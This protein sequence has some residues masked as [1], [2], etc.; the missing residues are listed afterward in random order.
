MT[1]IT[2]PAGLVEPGEDVMVVTLD[3]DELH[4]ARGH[5]MKYFLPSRRPSMCRGLIDLP[6]APAPYSE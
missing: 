1:T 2:V 4:N 6:Q 5:R 3:L